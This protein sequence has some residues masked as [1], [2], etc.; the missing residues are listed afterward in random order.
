VGLVARFL[1][2]DGFST[3]VLSPTPEFQRKVGMPRLA[4]IEYPYGRAIGQVGDSEGQKEVLLAALSCLQKAEESGQIFHLPFTW[5]ESPQ[6]T[7]WHP[8]EMSPVIKLFLGDVKKAA[9]QA[10][11]K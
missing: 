11:G 4:G 5:H 9:A 8:P 1:E 10:R 3:I 6:E 2:E 7:K